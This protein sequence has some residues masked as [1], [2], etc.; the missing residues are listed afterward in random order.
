MSSHLTAPVAARLY[1][2]S[3]SNRKASALWGKNQFNSAF[4]TALACYMRDKSIPAVYLSL[5][6]D[7]KVVVSEITIDELFNSEKPNEQLRFDFESPFA[8]YQNYALDGIRG[9]DLVVKNEG[10]ATDTGWRRALE[11]KLTVIPDNTTCAR[12]EAEWSP[13]LVIRPA[14]TKYCALGIYHRNRTRKDEIRDIF[15]QLCGNFQ[16]W[17]SPHELL[18]KQTAL[19]ASLNQFQATFKGAQQPFLIQPIWKTEGKSPSLAAKAFDLFV[20]SD[21]ALCRA[22]IEKSISFGSTLNKGL[23]CISSR[24]RRARGWFRSRT[25]V[26]TNGLPSS[27]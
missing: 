25:T 24:S 20:W 18:D 3:H 16:H 21:L 13:E 27:P 5:G 10:D 26:A 11:V 2:I 7:S 8:P 14:S 9:I 4:P 1:G 22:F 23:R 17:D 6:E 15:Q 19:L 12:P